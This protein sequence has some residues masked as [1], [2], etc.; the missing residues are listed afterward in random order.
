MAPVVLFYQ[1][2]PKLVRSEAV[3]VSGTEA[4]EKKKKGRLMKGDQ[5]EATEEVCGRFVIELIGSVSFLY[6]CYCVDLFGNAI[7]F[8]VNINVFVST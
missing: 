4:T 7:E 6:V 2:E 5:G 1:K 8:I 3:C